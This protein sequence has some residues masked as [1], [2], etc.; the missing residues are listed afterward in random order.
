MKMLTPLKG[1]LL[2]VAAYVLYVALT[3]TL[4]PIFG[5]RA[6][7]DAAL[8]A[9]TPSE[10]AERVACIDDNTDALIWRLRV[11]ESAQQELVLSSF[12][13]DDDSSGR[14][15]LAT[16]K[17]AADRGVH[18][19]I[20]LDGLRGQLS[21]LES[22]HFQAL[23][24]HKNIEIRLYNPINLL[25]PWE[26]NYRMHDK[27]LI[28]DDQVYLLGGRNTMDLFLGDYQD[29]KNI[30]RDV[31]VYNTTPDKP[32][33][34][35]QVKAYFENTWALPCC[36]AAFERPQNERDTSLL[37]LDSHYKMLPAFFPTAFEETD[38]IGST[39][40]AGEVRFL[41]NPNQK[42]VKD[43][44]LWKS[45]CTAM[46]HGE[47]V[48]IQTPYIICSREMYQGLDTLTDKDTRVQI[49][50]N[51]VE[52]GAN[53]WGCTDYL[54]HKKKILNT[55]VEVF[56]FIGEHSLHAKAILIDDRY[57]IIGSFNM[58]MRSAYLDTE[59]ML[60]IES[61][62]LNARLQSEISSDMTESVHVFPDGTE[63]A[64]ENYEPITLS[65]GKQLIYSLLR[66]LIIPF[67]HLL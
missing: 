36:R 37:E 59:T 11:I 22:P 14:D 56:E 10:A 42:Q 64:G 60:V 12:E 8:A 55:G 39:M 25:K 57:S 52:A 13:F 35:S 34:L 17:Q 49:I 2:L 44:Q 67:R 43:P 6:S 38:W 54:N 40:P 5:N 29:V 24:A 28:A 33:S 31:L 65:T 4:V 16:L 21:L 48:V 63:I 30:D 26:I 27:Y 19:R 51:A 23:A 45:L 1:L 9:P 20:L 18:V 53:P 7:L 41:S 47:D 15:M 46:T 3:C 32:S 58:D 61:P 62:E 50:T 66:L